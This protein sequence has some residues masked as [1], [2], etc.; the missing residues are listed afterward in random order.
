MAALELDVPLWSTLSNDLLQKVTAN[1]SLSKQRRLKVC[2]DSYEQDV[3][4]ITPGS[5]KFFPL[6]VTNDLRFSLGFESN[7]RRWCRLPTRSYLLEEIHDFKPRFIGACGSLF[8]LTEG[9]GNSP[10]FVTNAVT[11][12]W[13]QLPPYHTEKRNS[14]QI[15]C[16]GGSQTYKV[17]ISSGSFICIFDSTDYSWTRVYSLFGSTADINGVL[18]IDGYNMSYGSLKDRRY[19]INSF[20][21][22]EKVWKGF[23]CLDQVFPENPEKPPKVFQRG[24]GLTQLLVVGRRSYWWQQ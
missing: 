20:N 19:G 10:V 7:S 13:R 11:R 23:T 4:F 12:S 24:S 1:L 17:F 21:L 15:V 16:E 14:V 3:S 6:F 9:W 2:C 18:H 8:C 5:S 22:K